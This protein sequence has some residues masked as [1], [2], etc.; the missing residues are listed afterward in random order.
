MMQG[1]PWSVR[2]VKP[3]V[4]DAATQAAQQAGVTLGEWL[5]RVIADKSADTDSPATPAPPAPERS[6]AR[7][8]ADA[9][10]GGKAESSTL[11]ALDSVARWIETTDSSRREDTRTI[12]TNQDRHGTV[13]RDA[14]DHVSR[15]I[16]SIERSVDAGAPAPSIK[17][18]L[19]RIESRLDGKEGRP[20]GADRVDETLRELESRYSALARTLARPEPAP[21]IVIQ[22]APVVAPAAAAAPLASD[23]RLARAVAAIRAR[24]E[25]LETEPAVQPDLAAPQLAAIGADIAQLTRRIDAV[26]NAPPKAEATLQELMTG[27]RASLAQSDP[28]PKLDSFGRQ[29][30]A[31]AA[32]LDTLAGRMV[33]SDS[34]DALRGDVASLRAS[35]ETKARPAAPVTAA[36]EPD[37]PSAVLTALQCSVDDLTATLS[38]RLPPSLGDRLDALEQRIARISE[39]GQAAPAPN[40]DRLD[41]RLDELGRRIAAAGQSAAA[42]DFAPLDARLDTLASR[43]EELRKPDPDSDGIAALRGQIAEL[44]LR[45][46]KVDAGFRGVSGLERTLDEV[47]ARLQDGNR[48]TAE[49]VKSAAGESLRSATLADPALLRRID[50]RLEGLHERLASVAGRLESAPPATMATPAGAA[51]APPSRAAEPDKAPPA[52]TSAEK[53]AAATAAADAARA[54]VA[55]AQKKAAQTAPADPRRA[56]DPRQLVAAARA[57]AARAHTEPLELVPAMDA[58]RVAATIPVP[59]EDG[60]AAFAPVPADAEAGD[61]V[62][63]P[64]DALRSYAA[65]RRRPLLIGVAAAVAVIGVLHALRDEFAPA[66]ISDET[67]AEVSAPAETGRPGQPSGAASPS[68]DALVPADPAPSAP[69]N[70]PASVPKPQTNAE[71]A[72]LPKTA[73]AFS[74]FSPEPQTVG[75]LGKLNDMPEPP[76]AGTDL[77]ARAPAA[78]AP[79]QPFTEPLPAGLPALLAKGLQAGDPVAAYELSA[80]YADGRGGMPR[81]AKLAAVWL[82]QAA[83][84]GFAPA[85]YRLGS[86]YE[87]GLGVTRDPAKARQ[88][89]ETAADAGNVKAMHNLGVIY[90]DASSGKPDY[91]A[92]AIWFR[93]AA[94]YG[95]RDSQYNLA[96]LAGRGLGIPQNL[97]EAYLWFSLA[98]TQGD[99]DA[100]AK[101]EEVAARLDPA[102]LATAKATVQAFRVKTPLPAANEVTPP[103][104]PVAGDARKEKAKPAGT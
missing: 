11:Y 27:L 76:R 44:A 28:A 31:L 10:G 63:S 99:Q 61:A 90:A 18:A 103:A 55:Q 93:K 4:R 82:E 8:V 98:A 38:S 74:P 86:L 45:L 50:E 87:R 81:D 91:A 40:F 35:M 84:R 72:P 62:V 37:G 46:E 71:P 53:L 101:R 21:T 43:L 89:Y 33:P 60:P 73:Q 77:P 94:D 5:N 6:L 78:S 52:P 24:Q 92:A 3:E 88:W 66:P 75:S 96:V 32:R 47:M 51:A 56:V 29:L 16:E 12:V 23:E 64:I 30:D 26:L 79:R 20:A 42:P 102:S 80:R 39:T 36:R 57:A 34:L 97:P 25:T 9:L 100:A 95:L 83:Q 104:D 54:A 2:G 13:L 17:A 67:P 1:D 58:P 68:S 48:L 65:R 69:A 85:Q 14:I 49:A 15:K 7:A 22:T 19:D 41:A 59:A 70:A